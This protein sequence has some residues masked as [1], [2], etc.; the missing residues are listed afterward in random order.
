[1]YNHELYLWVKISE[2]TASS[3]T[4]T[5][6]FLEGLSVSAGTLSKQ[7]QIRGADTADSVAIIT[8]LPVSLP[9]TS[10]VQGTG[11]C[12]FT[13]FRC[14]RYYDQQVCIPLSK[15]L[16]DHYYH[17]FVCDWGLRN[18]KYSFQPR[19]WSQPRPCWLQLDGE[20]FKSIHFIYHSWMM[21]FSLSQ[22]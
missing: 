17:L 21:I 11:N 6:Q 22:M 15:N 10:V 3:H 13:V 19:Y 7:Q 8:L 14:L 20:K 4:C 5:H 18:E 9:M 12:N 16:L 1:M 2:D